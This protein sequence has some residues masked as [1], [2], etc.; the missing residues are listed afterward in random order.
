MSDSILLASSE[1]ELQVDET[2]VM[3]SD[4]IACRILIQNEQ[5][6]QVNTFQYLG[7]L[8]TEDGGWVYDR[9]PHQ[10]KQS[11][12]YRGITAENMEKSQ[13]T[14]FNEDKANES[15][16]VACSHVRLWKPDKIK[17]LRKI[18]RVLWTA[19]KVS[20]FST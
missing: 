6:A 20:E 1:A 13:H 5:L 14:D 8:I 2:K 19:K 17:G 10:V 12:G 3:A 9:I 4:G 7:S 18:L 15:A 11:A 16:G